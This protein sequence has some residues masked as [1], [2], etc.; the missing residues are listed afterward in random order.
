MDT[1]DPDIMF[2]SNGV[3]NN[4]HTFDQ[5]TSKRWFPNEE[6]KEILEKRLESI[7]NKYSN[8]EYDCIIGLSGGIDS[9]YLAL[10]LKDYGLR[11]LV[12]HVD[13]GWNS[14]V[15]VSN[16]EKIVKYC[17]YDLH[18]HVLDWEEVK[19][20]QLSYLKAG[21]ANQDVPQDHGFNASLYHFAVKNNIKHIISGG[22]IATEGVFP[23]SWLHSAM[24]SINLHAIHKAY[25]RRELKQYRTISTLQYYISYPIFYKLR[26]IRPLNF[27]NY[28]RNDAIK[29][30]KSRIGYKDYGYKHC[31]SIF[32]KF[33]QNYYLPEKFGYDKRRPHY[34]SMILSGQLDRDIALKELEKP[35]YDS[36]ELQDDIEYISKKIQITT[37]QLKSYISAPGRCYSDFDNWDKYYNLLKQ[38]QRIAEKFFGMEIKNYG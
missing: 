28:N 35:L 38:L 22:N 3:C 4:C 9:S 25:G 11:P 23:N 10:L 31:E 15:A 21:I 20:L 17:N 16:I 27:F 30:L 5:I 26:T 18:T 33:Y 14:E 19:D 7:K 12:V 2:D 34:S 29:L 24:D 6:G 36:F 1:S 37:D 8:Q 32:T 13:A